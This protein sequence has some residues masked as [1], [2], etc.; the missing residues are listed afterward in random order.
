MTSI[1][2]QRLKIIAA[3]LIVLSV[4]SLIMIM[5]HYLKL[6]LAYLLIHK[7]LNIVQTKNLK[8][9]PVLFQFTPT[10][11]VSYALAQVD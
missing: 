5:I 11:K 2:M 10:K 1:L 9:N 3:T 6:R 4:V 7:N 8:I